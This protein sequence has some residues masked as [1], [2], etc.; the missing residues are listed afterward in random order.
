MR[1]LV[2]FFYLLVLNV[3]IKCIDQSH[4]SKL[5]HLQVNAYL[6]RSNIFF[7]SF[8]VEKNGMLFIE[9]S[10]INEINVE[11][12]FHMILAGNI[13]FIFHIIFTNSFCYRNLL[14]KAE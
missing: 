2:S 10:A 3:M 9:T 7:K 5:K 4:V 6:F 12:A 14:Q 1:L 11:K 8:I 13:I